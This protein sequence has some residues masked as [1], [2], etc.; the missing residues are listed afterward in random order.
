[1]GSFA[2]GTFRD[3]WSEGEEAPRAD[4]TIAGASNNVL[5]SSF[6]NGNVRFSR[7]LDTGDTVGDI[8]LGADN[9]ELIWSFNADN[10]DFSDGHDSRGSSSVN[11]FS[12]W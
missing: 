3:H 9:F 7:A 10:A 1:M 4:N 11:L 6:V 8:V 12:N 5:S 2:S